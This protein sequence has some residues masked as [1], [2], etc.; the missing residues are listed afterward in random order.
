M[1]RRILSASLIA[2]LIQL[3]GAHPIMANSPKKEADQIEKVRAGIARLGVG[4]QARVKLKLRDNTR[5]EGYVSEAGTDHF[6]VIE[7]QT[8]AATSLQYSQV[9]Q[10]KGNNLS[11]GA[12]IGIGI[13]AA[14]GVAL[15]IAYAVFAANER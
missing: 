9:K 6:T 10:V 15:L 11:K 4:P 7:K 8:G 5:L 14:L 2:M 3:A 1:F 12:K 13:G